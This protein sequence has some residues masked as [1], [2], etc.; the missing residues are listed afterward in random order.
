MRE[1][2]AADGGEG[3]GEGDLSEGGVVRERNGADGGQG[4]RERELGERGATCLCGE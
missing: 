1:G 3:G 2:M 4:I